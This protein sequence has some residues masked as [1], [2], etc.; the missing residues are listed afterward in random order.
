MWTLAPTGGFF[1]DRKV[2]AV[3]F[4]EE[5]W[6]PSCLPKAK[7]QGIEVVEGKGGIH[8]LRESAVY[9]LLRRGSQARCTP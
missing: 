7:E 6:N 5:R 8:D 9:A 1:T 4:E 3:I 2:M